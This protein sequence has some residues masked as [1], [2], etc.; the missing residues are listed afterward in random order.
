M[1]DL[2]QNTARKQDSYSA[3][4]IEVLE[5]LEPVR[6]RPGMY[7]GGTDERAL[8]HL[9]AEVLDN[10][11]DEAV[12]GH[13]NRI[14]L[15]L[16]ADGTVSIR[17]NGRGIPVDDHPKYPGKSALEVILTTLHSGGKFSGKVY[18]TSGGLHGVGL[19]VVT[20]LTDQLTVEVA[21]DRTLYTQSYSRGVPLTPLVNAG[22]VNNRRGTLVRFHPDAQIFGEGAHFKA[23]RLYRMARSKAYL[24]RGVEIRWSCDPSLLS[25]DSAVPA[26]ETLH[27]PNGLLDYLMSALKDRRTVTPTAF[28]GQA[29]FPNQAGRVE[30]AVAWPEDDEGFSHT[31]CNTI[32][33]PQ[34]GTHEQG[35][36]QALTRGLKG[37]GELVG[38]R[39]GPSLTAED[40]V[41]GATILLSVFIRDPQFQGQTKEKLVSA[42]AVRLTEAAIK[43]HFD[44]W[45]SAAPDAAKVLL[46][47]LVE[48]AEE[49][50]RR[51]AAKDMARKTPTRRL[52]LPGKL[53]DCS[54][55]SSEGTEIFI[56]E[57]DSAGGS[58]K[59]ARNRET[60]A[61]LPLRG[62]ILNV[63]SA[64]TDK[65]RG[66]QELSDLV[67]ALGC[68]AGKD[69]SPDRLRYER[70]VIM[71][72]ADVDGAHIASLLMT[73]FY[74]EMPALIQN[75]NLYLALPPLYR[76]SQ[77]SNVRYARD[78][79]HKD[80]L[81]ATVFKANQK[82]EI[83]RFKGLGE[84]QPSQ[85]K[86]TT[87]D[88]ARR[89]L[90]RVTVPDIRDPDQK[91]DAEST[92]SLVESLMGRKPELRF[93]FIQENAKFAQD[94]DV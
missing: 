55:Q 82:V 90:L 40:V 9:V 8:H 29:D 41:D 45:L 64:S 56:V 17:D 25:D 34:G 2:F 91:D 94:L 11:M 6:R 89:T 23:E 7:I 86:E 48:K 3:Q 66:N 32:P 62:K 79:A 85:L 59:Q 80:E 30:W 47:R 5:G 50:A 63:A 49:R 38:N 68:G 12:A 93:K 18:A 19:S 61:I 22:P 54:R 42:E 51:R 52:R 70:I 27:F 28:A 76:L 75:G 74:R 16:A 87:M 15:E 83:S 77:G 10:A 72:D 69:F 33:T 1:S 53:A 21:R 67:Q 88:P 24:F 35:L 73:F 92:A 46:D 37:Y 57:G 13:A 31:Y 65:L 36:R 20:A 4:D 81:L 58:A 14:D 84:M 44:H 26:S 43:D 39:K 78:D 71:T 60:Q